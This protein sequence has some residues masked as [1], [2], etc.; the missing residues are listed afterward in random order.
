ML[1]TTG[2]NIDQPWVGANTFDGNAY[3]WIPQ[4]QDPATCLTECRTPRPQGVST[5]TGR[6]MNQTLDGQERTT[7][8]LPALSTND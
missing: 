6:A 8:S 5:G 1:R 2:V 7:P 3:S 4:T